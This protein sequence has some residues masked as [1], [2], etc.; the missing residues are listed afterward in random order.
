MPTSKQIARIRQ[1]PSMVAPGQRSKA[2]MTPVPAWALASASSGKAMIARA[3]IVVTE[4]AMTAA[5]PM[6]DRSCAPRTRS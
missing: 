1:K 5:R 4:R 6:S 2:A 3:R